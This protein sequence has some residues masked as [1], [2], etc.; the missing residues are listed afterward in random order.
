MSVRPFAFCY[1]LPRIKG[2]VTNRLVN[3]LGWRNSLYVSAALALSCSLIT[4]L[5]KPLNAYEV[6][7]D[8]DDEEAANET[9]YLNSN[10]N[11]IKNSISKTP[12]G[13]AQNGSTP[14]LALNEVCKVGGL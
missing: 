7:D 6:S 14:S 9:N 8:L 10:N 13:N 11:I 5:F 12:N 4:A 1:L 2:P 3:E